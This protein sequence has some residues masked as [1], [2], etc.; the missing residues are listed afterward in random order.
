MSSVKQPDV[1][2]LLE[3]QNP[4][5][6]LA[7]VESAFDDSTYTHN[8]NFWAWILVQIN[9]RIFENPDQPHLAWAKVSLAIYEGLARQ[10]AAGDHSTYMLD[11]M[12]LRVRLIR[13]SAT[14]A[15]E[16]ILDPS[17]V[18]NWFWHTL[19]LAYDEAESQITQ[20]QTNPNQ[21]SLE[22]IRQLRLLKQ[23]IVRVD[24]LISAHK[25][26]PS[27]DLRLWL[28]LKGRLP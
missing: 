7:W 24:T 25:I 4:S 9:H 5:A 17:A 3:G 28:A 23:K 22:M 8:A 26:T 16:E 13:E 6:V 15:D 10:S 21:L 2:T 19:P 14:I 11:A 27:D 12:G 1:I 18:T 20:W